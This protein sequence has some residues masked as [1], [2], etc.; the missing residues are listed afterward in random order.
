MV[1]QREVVHELLREYEGLSRRGV[2]QILHAHRGHELEQREIEARAQM[3]EEVTAEVG[4]I[5]AE[6]APQPR[7]DER[8]ET[9]QVP[10]GER[11]RQGLPPRVG[12]QRQPLSAKKSCTPDT[13]PSSVQK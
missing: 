8:E 10:R 4:A 2:H 5:D 13:S 3:D 6:S 11:G 7:D 1:E 12:M 9:P